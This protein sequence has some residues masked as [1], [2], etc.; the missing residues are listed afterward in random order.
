MH[1]AGSS[2]WHAGSLVAAGGLLSSCGAQAPECAGSVVAARRLSC[3]TAR[4]ISFPRPGI[5]PSSPAL[6]GRFVTTGPPGK[7]PYISFM[8]TTLCFYFCVTYSMLTTKNLVSIH[9]HTVDPFY[10]FHPP[11]PPPLPLW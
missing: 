7:S 1:H 4:G 8:C 10:P 3:S 5:E 9:H 6:E 2:L 11:P